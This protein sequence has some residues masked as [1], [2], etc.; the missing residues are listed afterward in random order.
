MA[1]G[2]SEG[3]VWVEHKKLED[4]QGTL[5]EQLQSLLRAFGCDDN[6]PVHVYTFKNEGK[7]DQYRVLVMIPRELTPFRS[8][9]RGEGWSPLAAYQEALV[10]ALAVIR[11]E[12]EEELEGTSL[13]A[14]P[15]NSLSLELELDHSIIVKT[16][17]HKAI[18]L[19]DRYKSLVGGF[20]HSHGIITKDRHAG[21]GN[22]EAPPKAE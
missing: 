4:F 13:L 19:L 3:S 8:T 7:V 20:F 16:R 9:P 14:I 15:H 18:K 1:E 22:V 2:N 6:I 11:E 5:T 12:K 10:E 17:P 21:L